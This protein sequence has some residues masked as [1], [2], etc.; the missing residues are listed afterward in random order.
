MSLLDAEPIP[1]P[2]ARPAAAPPAEDAAGLDRVHSYEAMQ[3]AAGFLRRLQA[4]EQ[5]SLREIGRR[6]GVAIRQLSLIA[7]AKGSDGPQLATLF[8]IAA[9]FGRKVKLD[10]P[11]RRA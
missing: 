9:A 3:A 11:E 4:E 2:K 10:A 7:N 5:V 8:K 6:S 1:R